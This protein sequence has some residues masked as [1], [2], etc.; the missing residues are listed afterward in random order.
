MAFTPSQRGPRLRTYG[1]GSGRTGERPQTRTDDPALR[2]IGHET[3][4]ISLVDNAYY[5]LGSI[6]A[7][8]QQYELEYNHVGKTFNTLVGQTQLATL[9]V[10]ARSAKPN[11]VVRFT[12]R[13]ATGGSTRED[14]MA[15]SNR[16]AAT[17]FD[18]DATGAENIFT[19]EAAHGLKIGDFVYLVFD[20]D[21]DLTGAYGTNGLVSEI[22][23]VWMAVTAVADTTT[24]ATLTVGSADTDDADDAALDGQFWVAASNDVQVDFAKR[25]SNILLADGA[26]GTFPLAG[27]SLG[28]C[29]DLWDGQV[30]L[31]IPL[32]TA[33]S[34]WQML[35][36][37]AAPIVNYAD[38]T[39]TWDDDGSDGD[40]GLREHSDHI[41]YLQNEG[42][43]SFTFNI[44]M[45]NSPV[46]ADLVDAIDSTGIVV[47]DNE[48]WIVN[49]TGSTQVYQIRRTA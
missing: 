28:L 45:R 5:N 6:P 30:E 46:R 44:V 4:G 43:A 38:S 9:R 29:S 17:E 24:F 37:V 39:I 36:G 47:V 12:E 31:D 13:A 27:A 19:S 8:A 2:V 1:A 10:P 33:R 11:E 40:V 48:L 21:V 42:G 7:V 3:S 49:R 16:V 41:V 18:V 23:S 20:A 25:V 14:N 26:Q 32:Q 15:T 34:D 35:G 22:D